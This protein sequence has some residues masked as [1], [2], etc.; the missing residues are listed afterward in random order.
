VKQA[1]PGCRCC[2]DMD[3]PSLT[4]LTGWPDGSRK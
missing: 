3:A 1:V 4:G 2:F